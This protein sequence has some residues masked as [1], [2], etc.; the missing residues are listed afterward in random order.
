M[1]KNCPYGE[2]KHKGT[3]NWIQCNK[4]NQM[5]MFQRYCIKERKVVFTL[6]A[7]NCKLRNNE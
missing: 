3:R 6:E 5:C 2:L 7:T 1:N 4:T